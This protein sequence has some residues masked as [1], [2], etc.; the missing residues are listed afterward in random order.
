MDAN[1]Y[2]KLRDPEKALYEYQAGILD[3]WTLAERIG[4]PNMGKPP[5]WAT[6]VAKRLMAQRTMGLGVTPCCGFTTG[7][8]AHSAMGTR[9]CSMTDCATPLPNCTHGNPT[10]E[11]AT[12]A[13][14]RIRQEIDEWMKL[15]LAQALV[16]EIVTDLIKAVLA[17][18]NERLPRA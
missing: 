1:E 11:E 6:T 5:E 15:P 16:A 7:P 14:Y 4:I 12:E 17:I 13:L 3:L 2:S 9:R 18:A 8:H 10:R